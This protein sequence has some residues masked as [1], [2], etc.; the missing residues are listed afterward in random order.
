MPSLGPT[1]TPRY[2]GRLTRRRIT[3]SRPSAATAATS[4]DGPSRDGKVT[5][6]RRSTKST[7][8]AV[9]SSVPAQAVKPADQPLTETLYGPALAPHHGRK[10]AM[11]ATP[12]PPPIV[13]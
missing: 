8:A 6:E 4:T 7:P 12:A 9:R 10:P 5:P 2:G 11:N 3:S 1:S 13:R